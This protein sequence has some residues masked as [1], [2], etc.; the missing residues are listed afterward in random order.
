MRELKYIE[1]NEQ[2][3]VEYDWAFIRKEFKKLKIQL[4]QILMRLLH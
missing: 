3:G 2:F 1:G 4:L